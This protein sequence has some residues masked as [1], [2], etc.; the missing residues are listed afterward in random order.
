[1]E[2]EEG[3]EQEVMG[4]AEEED[5]LGRLVVYHRHHLL[6][7]I[8]LPQ[9]TTRRICSGNTPLLSPTDIG[10]SLTQ[11]SRAKVHVSTDTLPFKA[12]IHGRR[13]LTQA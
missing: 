6:L 10:E 9:Q 8:L 13:I 1:M 2:E 5:H 7:L 12:S 11:S 4:E 3:E